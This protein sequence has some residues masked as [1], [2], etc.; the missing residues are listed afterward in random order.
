LVSSCLLRKQRKNN[1]EKQL[2]RIIVGDETENSD[3]I[4][5][6]LIVF[7]RRFSNYCPLKL[8]ANNNFS[9]FCF[10]LSSSTLFFSYGEEI[11]SALTNNSIKIVARESFVQKGEKNS[12]KI[13][14][15]KNNSGNDSFVWKNNRFQFS[16][17]LK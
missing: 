16:F 7:P 9:R 4:F 10:I 1:N 13:Q 2:S 3:Q 8:L 6:K 17:E 5:I 11:I 12:G 15:E 14:I